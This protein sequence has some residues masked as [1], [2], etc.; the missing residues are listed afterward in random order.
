MDTFDIITL[1]SH[2]HVMDINI[3]FMPLVTFLQQTKPEGQEPHVGKL[4]KHG[5]NHKRVKANWSLGVSKV[6]VGIIKPTTTH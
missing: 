5:T 2:C 3:S 1:F 6:V 4:T